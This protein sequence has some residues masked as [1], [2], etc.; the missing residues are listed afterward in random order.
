MRVCSAKQMQEAEQALITSGTSALELMEEAASGIADAILQ[1]FPSPGLCIAYLGKGNNAGDAVTILRI[2]QDHGWEIGI[3]SAWPEEMWSDLLLEQYHTLHPKPQH[4]HQ[5]AIPRYKQTILLDGLLGTGTRGELSSELGL[6]CSEINYLRSQYA[7]VR[8]VAIDVP[9]GVHPDTGIPALDSVE[10]D[11]TGCIGAVKCGLLEDTATLHV[12][13]IWPIPL[14]GLTPQS[15]H[16]TKVSGSTM[17]SPFLAPR[18]YDDYKNRKGHVGIIAGSRGMLGAARLCSE[19]ALRAGAG[20][21]TVHALEED[22]PI[23]SAIMPPEIMVSPIRSYHDIDIKKFSAFL[24]GPGLGRI[25]S[26]NREAI[27]IILSLGTPVVLDADGLNMVAEEKW[28]LGKHVLATPHPGEMA[29]LLPHITPMS[30]RAEIIDQF[31]QEHDAAVIYKGARSLITQ[32][33]QPLYYN[34]SG[35]PAMATAGQGDVL[36]GVC[37]GWCAQGE[38][39]LVAGVLSAFLCGRASE[40][41]LSNLQS[42]EQT[43]TAGDTIK[44]LPQ[45]IISTGQLCY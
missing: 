36:A 41:A 20:L 15:L 6:L 2:L 31:C 13:R 17:L 35:G 22:Y 21:V 1:H 10:A 12:G 34:I 7:C 25:Q 26:E 43:F 32:H 38:S 27:R 4:I 39:P 18:P 44:F 11:F 45:A 9:S 8:V 37:A 16:A 23:L 5:V 33:N 19:A 30:N 29:S 24:I 3:R 40:I 28:R 42:T 14:T